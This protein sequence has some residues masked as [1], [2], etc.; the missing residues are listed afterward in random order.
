MMVLRDA[1]ADAILD[2]I[3]DCGM[4]QGHA[5]FMRRQW[6]LLKSGQ[7]PE[8]AAEGELERVM[9]NGD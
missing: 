2:L 5:K 7:P 8:A 6:A 1:D 3:L 9:T 4:P